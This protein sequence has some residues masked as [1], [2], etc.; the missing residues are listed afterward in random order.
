M[1]SSIHCYIL[2]IF[3]PFTFVS[4]GVH[5][6]WVSN[7]RIDPSGYISYLSG[8]DIGTEPLMIPT[9]PAK[10]WTAQAYDKKNI[11]IHHEW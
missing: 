7:D 1:R 2:Y 9:V 11:S 4:L 8:C 5:R 3:H 10:A 6:G